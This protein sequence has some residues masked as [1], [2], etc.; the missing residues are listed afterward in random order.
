[1][2]DNEKRAYTNAKNHNLDNELEDLEITEEHLKK[3]LGFLQR[4]AGNTKVRE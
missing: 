3:Q 2:R 1:M 4:K